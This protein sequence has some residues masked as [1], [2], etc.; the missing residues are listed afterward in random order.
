M[1]KT[2]I[3]YL[4]AIIRPCRNKWF[5]EMQSCVIKSK[6]LIP[7]LDNKEKTT[8]QAEDRYAREVTLM[9]L[10]QKV[11]DRKNFSG[12]WITLLS[13]IFEIPKFESLYLYIMTYV[14]WSYMISA[15]WFYTTCLIGIGNQCFLYDFTC[16]CLYKKRKSRTHS[17]LYADIYRPGFGMLH[18]V[19]SDNDLYCSHFMINQFEMN[20]IGSSSISSSK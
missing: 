19:Y 20:R 14:T 5:S 9:L 2:Y 1:R 7:H 3:I 11:E 17:N 13:L 10:L 12:I 8:H 18:H 4:Y 16:I 15:Y 6:M